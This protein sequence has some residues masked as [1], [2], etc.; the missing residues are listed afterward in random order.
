[1]SGRP[2]GQHLGLDQRDELLVPGPGVH[3]GLRDPLRDQ[4]REKPAVIQAGEF[5]LEGLYHAGDAGAGV[6]ICPPIDERVSVGMDA[7]PVAEIAYACA[8][9]KRPSLRFQHR[10]HGASTGPRDPAAV[11]DDA[12]FARRHL[13]ETT[14]SFVSIAG[15]LKGC[16]TAVALSLRA[17]RIHDLLLVAPPAP[18][19][20]SEVK[21]RILVIIPATD[22]AGLRWWQP[23]M[24][25]LRGTL[26]PIPDADPAFTKGLSTMSRIIR[27]WLSGMDPTV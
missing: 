21:R 9:A 16:G 24:D 22:R 18:L 23:Q 5:W 27:Q 20:V 14:G 6:L 8:A 13:E 7:P 3:L 15:Y 25:N 1:L 2:P 11:V 12:D 19:E 10:G 4:F 17:P 26:I